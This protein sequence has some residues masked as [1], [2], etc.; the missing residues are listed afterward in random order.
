[1]EGEPIEPK[2]F[3]S[4]Y[5]YACVRALN[6]RVRGIYCTKD[7]FVTTSLQVPNLRIAWLESQTGVSYATLRR[8]YGKWM[9]RGG[10]SE[11]QKFAALDPSLF[12]PRLAPSLAPKG[13]SDAE[14]PDFA[15]REI[16]EEGDLNPKRREELSGE[17]S[18]SSRQEPPLTATMCV[19]RTQFTVRET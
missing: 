1:M 7:T 13:D 5:W 19:R 2:A 14:V 6:I 4:R 8:H 11:L 3:A 12:S 15:E 16:C 18:V 10:D 17:F 9:P